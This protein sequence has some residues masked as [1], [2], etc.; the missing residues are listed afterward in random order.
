MKV[1]YFNKKMIALA[2]AGTTGFSLTGCINEVTEL[3]D[4]NTEYDT[5]N[6]NDTMEDTVESTGN[7]QKGIKQIK[8]INDENFKL[9][10]EYQCDNTWR[11]TDTKSLFM[12]IYTE[13]LKENQKVYIDNI[14]MD[15][16]IV[17]TNTYFD[18][19]KQDTLDDRIHNSQMIGFPISDT[20]HYYGINEIEG[21]NAEFMEGFSY[22]M[23][24]YHSSSYS[25]KR[26]L[27]SDYLEKGVYAN[28][29]DG[30]ID[31]LIEDQETKEIR[32][33]SVD[34]SLVVEVNNKITFSVIGEKEQKQ[35]TY[36][37]DKYGN[38][39]II[40]EIDLG[41]VKQKVKK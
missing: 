37:Y 25:T 1:K 30:V 5:I 22:G 34:T 3:S 40:E 33:V 6:T 36:E 10:I 18:G 39:E 31:L 21:Q 41:P 26:Y 20:N 19:I 8:E 2:L 28:K 35:I 9:V 13:G 14:H 27:E 12:S 15:T 11:I 7:L 38:S 16:S 17:S 23:N 24:G 32:S 29:I 4:D